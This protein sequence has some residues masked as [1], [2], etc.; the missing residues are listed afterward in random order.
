[1]MD[2]KKSKQIFMTFLIGAFYT[3]DLQKFVAHTDSKQEMIRGPSSLPLELKPQK[4][5]KQ[6]ELSKKIH[7]ERKNQKL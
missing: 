3:S 4:K 2:S 1:M 6:K 7:K 5:K